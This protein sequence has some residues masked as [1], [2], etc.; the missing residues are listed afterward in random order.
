MFARNVFVLLLSKNTA[1]V[2]GRNEV[3]QRE[4]KG[5]RREIKL[6]EQHVVRR[7]VSP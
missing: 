5:N 3:L 7:S 4:A 1:N 2:N 6:T